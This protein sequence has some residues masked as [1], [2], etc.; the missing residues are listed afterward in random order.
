MGGELLLRPPDALDLLR[1]LESVKA[2]ILGLDTW[3]VVPAGI[4]ETLQSL[5]V[6]ETADARLSAAEARAFIENIVPTLNLDYVSFVV[7]DNLT[8][9]RVNERTNTQVMPDGIC[10]T[11]WNKLRGF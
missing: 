7:A 4:I 9:L 5:V 3:R 11:I 10:K 6:D 2:I 8:S 1:E